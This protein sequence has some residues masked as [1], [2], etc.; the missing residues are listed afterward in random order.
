MGCVTMVVL[1]VTDVGGGVRQ[2]MDVDVFCACE[3]VNVWEWCFA[4]ITASERRERDLLRGCW[5]L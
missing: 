1:V 5:G 2:G 3:C 4:V